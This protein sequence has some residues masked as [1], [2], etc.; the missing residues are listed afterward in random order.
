[1]HLSVRT[2][3]LLRGWMTETERRK[4]AQ[5]GAFIFISARF[6]GA[7]R[8][9]QT[10][11]IRNVM[12]L[13]NPPYCTFLCDVS[14]LE[15]PKQTPS[16][17][18]EWEEAADRE[19]YEEETL[20]KNVVVGRFAVFFAASRRSASD[21][22]QDA[23]VK[24][25]QERAEI[26]AKYDKGKEAVVEPWED[27]NFH[28]YKVIDRFGFVHENELPS[29]DSVE[30]KQ[31]HM[32]VERTTKW[33]KMLKSWD[34]YKNS[35]KLVRRI[36]KGIPLQLRGE[37][38]CL[39]LDVPK[40][41][42]E[43]KDFYEKLKA[44]ARGHSPDIRQIDLD[45][46]R[47]YR[48]HIMFMHRYD[49][50]QQALF[51]VLTAYSMYN[52]EV[53][54]CQGMSQITAL[55]LIYMNEEDAFWALVKLLSGQKH[56]MHGFFVPGFPKLMRFQ[57]HHDRILKKMIPKLK[58]HLDN[59]E[60]FTSLYTMKWFFQ[61][62]LD[63]TPFTLTLRIWDIYILEGE[64]LLPAMSY[65]IL[66]LHKKHLMKLSMEELV[67]F[68]Q[69]T[70]SKDFFFEDDFVIEQLQ[71]S[72][73][74]LRRAKLDLPAPGKEEEFPKKPL[75]QLPP[76]LAAAAV[77]HVPNGQSHAEPPREPSPQPDRQR[78]SRPPSRARRDSLE[79]THRHHKAERRDARS[80]GS[81][82]IANE[83]Q[84]QSTSTTPERG[85]TP[86][87]APTPTSQ[88]STVDKRKPQSHATANHNSNAASSSHRDFTP[89]WFKPSETK[90]EAAK[91]AAAREVQL[92][93]GPSPAP[94]SPDDGA[95][96]HRRPRSKGFIPGSNRG[97]NASQ[98]DNVPGLPEQNFEIQELERPPSRMRTP[99]SETPFSVSSLHQSS[100]GRGPSLAGSVVSVASGPRVAKH[101]LPPPFSSPAGVQASY[102][103]SQSQYHSPP[104][105]HSPGRT[106]TEVPIF[107][108]TY[109]VSL[110]HRGED[111]L[112]ALPPR[113]TPSSSVAYGE[114]P[115]ATTQRQPNSLSPEKVFMNNSYTTYRRQP[116][117]SSAHNPRNAR[118]AAEHSLQLDPQGRSTPIY[119]QQLTSTSQ[120][121]APMDYR[122]EGHRRVEANPHYMPEGGPQ[123]SVD[124][125]EWAPEDE[126]PPPSPGGMP[127]SPS[128]Q[129]AQMSPVQEFTF[130]SNPDGLLHY[131]TQFQEQ[132]PVIRQQLPQLFG[133]PHYR[134]AQEA[135]AMQESML[136]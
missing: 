81:G 33:L 112:Y 94:S 105:Q 7:P 64:R 38:W 36:Y 71:A 56:A 63:R 107:H 46:N 10:V 82:E 111:R 134:H 128:F 31:K 25:D 29:Y 28:L 99:R 16:G 72:M 104:Q 47:T 123:R 23:A 115:Y 78:D 61:C 106:T 84:K 126:L 102:P 43:K 74:E 70:L 125:L 60:V 100:P 12:S 90:L 86:T 53:G 75:G 120:V 39:L 49:V 97:S 52:T 4:E 17:V 24:L 30:E 27:T 3:A 11:E 9:S 114:Q 108:P 131:R 32:E 57:E 5:F 88:F 26:V 76:E 58:Q 13:R 45:V 79:K 19:R 117:P 55:L 118:P 8:S 73:T 41:K 129:R 51:H 35:E 127:R 48:D 85:A 101:S 50:K 68:L 15:V 65:T 18:M 20:C 122:F 91:Q 135:F 113:F 42:E 89:R 87:S 95:Q 92:S 62:F 110:D 98:Y 80:R 54:Y 116:P 21:T 34:K 6:V 93:R 133:G 59:Q 83:Q 132:Q 37:V 109:S 44:R 96:L 66:K 14:F 69:A 119:L 67:E 22:E 1:M 136:L 130:P 103:G 40:I 121:Y 2:E 124:G 77:N